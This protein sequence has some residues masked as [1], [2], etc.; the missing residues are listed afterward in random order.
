MSE[1]SIK[2]KKKF[3]YFDA[4][5]RQ[6]ELALEE[7]QLLVETVEN[8]DPDVDFRGVLEKA[9][10]IEHRGDN[11]THDIFT[12]IATDFITPIER[13]D[14]ISLAQVFDDIL[15]HIEDA[16]QLFYMYDIAEMHENTSEFAQIIEK[17]AKAL[18]NIMG[19]FR[20]FKK[21]K[22]FRRKIIEINTY[23]EEADELF[24]K[25][26]R[27]MYKTKQDDPIFV[28]QWSQIFARLEKCTDSCE[29][30]ADDMRMIMLK[31]S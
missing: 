12:A 8:Y 25:I 10:E 17:S 6:V 20:N 19:D 5:E 14:I 2:K 31:N 30:A 27:T 22:N 11:I 7:A 28:M 3:D 15:D 9:H 23:E 29:H 24:I 18:C 1:K 4:F 13:E 21:S 26:I 16:I